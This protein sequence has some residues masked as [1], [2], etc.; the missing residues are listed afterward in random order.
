MARSAG[1]PADSGAVSTAWNRHRL[2]QQS[3]TLADVDGAA[4]TLFGGIHPVLLDA[5]GALAARLDDLQHVLGEGPVPESFRTAAIVMV[6]DLPARAPQ[7]RW[8]VFTAAAAAAGAAAVLAIPL[9]IGSTPFGVLMIHRRSPGGWR[10]DA[11]AELDQL[12]RAG[13]RFLLADFRAA[14][15][16]GT[17]GLGLDSELLLGDNVVAQATGMLSVRL[18]L[19]VKAAGAYLR[20]RAFATDQSLHEVAIRVVSRTDVDTMA[21]RTAPDPAAWA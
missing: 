9:C 13:A 20:A 3:L 17:G 14:T 15:T 11:L 7:L 16:A 19:D 6:T 18:E 2:S 10:D 21:H 4:V 5:S 8:P 12:A 1:G